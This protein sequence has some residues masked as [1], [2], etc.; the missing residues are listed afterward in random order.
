MSD[1]FYVEI[2]RFSDGHVESRMGPMCERSAERVQRG[3]MI[4]MNHAE[5]GCRIVPV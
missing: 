1:K 4:N 3:A 5:W 2:W